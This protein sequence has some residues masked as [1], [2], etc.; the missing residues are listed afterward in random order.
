MKKIYVFAIACVFFLGMQFNTYGQAA[1]D[2]GN[3]LLN[4]GLGVGYYYAG[5][6]PLV[7]SAEFAIN[8]AIT[9]GP[10]LG[11]TSY[12]YRF[13]SGYRYTF[14]DIGVRGAYHFSKHI[15]LNTDKLDLYGGALLGYVA[16]SYTGDNFGYRDPYGATVRFGVFG[17]ARW[18]F[19]EKVAVNGEVGYGVAAM[20][21]GITFKLG[22]YSPLGL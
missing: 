1:I 13:S 5:G 7:I 14:V 9:I 10:Y 12:R 4:L 21:V 3:V 8:D 17:G 19:A 11:Y 20:L 15:N 18:Y 6:V 22:R 2:K 16:S